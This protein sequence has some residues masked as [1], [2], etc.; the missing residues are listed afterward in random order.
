[1][2]APSP[3]PGEHSPGTPIPTSLCSLSLQVPLPPFSSFLGLTA[4]QKPPSPAAAPDFHLP[5]GTLSVH[6]CHGR[7]HSA[8]PC[9][10][11]WP[12]AAWDPGVPLRALRGRQ[13]PAP[14]HTLSLGCGGWGEGGPCGDT[15]KPA[16]GIKLGSARTDCGGPGSELLPLQ[17]APP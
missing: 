2:L 11:P 12:K 10:Q 3:R 6:S 4:L 1:M 14:P 15:A 13:L 8:S 5:P 17:P 7:C 16:P 9:P